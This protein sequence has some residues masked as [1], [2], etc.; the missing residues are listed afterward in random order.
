MNISRSGFVKVAAAAGLVL[1]ALGT[2]S[3]A[4]ARSNVFF[5]IGANVA[6]GVSLGVSNGF[7]PA[8]VYAQPAPV[9]YQPA[10]VYYQPAPVYYE[11]QPVYYQPSVYVA[12]P[13]YRVGYGRPYYHHYNHYRHYR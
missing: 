9:Y 6:P 11:P 1:A 13:V 7:Y 12:P 4:E 5:S 2:A 8:P 10:P 3:V